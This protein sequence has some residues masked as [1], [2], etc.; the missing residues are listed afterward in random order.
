MVGA[1]ERG[2]AA[3]KYSQLRIALPTDMPHL[4]SGTRAAMAND[5]GIGVRT[6]VRMSLPLFVSSGFAIRQ[7]L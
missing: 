1:C 6:I 5:L 3:S 7:P 2:G 4:E